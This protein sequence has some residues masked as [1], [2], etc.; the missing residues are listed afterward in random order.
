MFQTTGSKSHDNLERIIYS[1][2]CIFFLIFNEK[3]EKLK[4]L[5]NWVPF[6]KAMTDFFHWTEN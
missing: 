6:I 5:E 1:L 4:S 2:S 3:K